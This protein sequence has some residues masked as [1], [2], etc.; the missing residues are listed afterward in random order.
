MKQLCEVGSTGLL[1]T[2]CGFSVPAK[3]GHPNL[4]ETNI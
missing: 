2:E 1:V 3:V 4:E